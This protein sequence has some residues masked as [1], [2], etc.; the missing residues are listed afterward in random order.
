MRTMVC[1]S[2]PRS[3]RRPAQLHQLAGSPGGPVRSSTPT[4]SPCPELRPHHRATSSPVLRVSLSNTFVSAITSRTASKIRSGSER[5]S[6]L[7][8]SASTVG[9]KPGSVIANPARYLH[10]ISRQRLQRVTIRDPSSDCNT[11][12]VATRSA[13][14]ATGDPDPTG[15]DRRTCHRETADAGARPRTRTPTP[16][17]PDATRTPPHRAA[18]GHMDTFP[19]SPNFR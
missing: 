8:H 17:G 9:W 1:R 19:A 2:W 4:A 18:R 10:R 5:R 7:R 13:G 16:A 3:H 14:A 6:L 11:S 12:T 15:T